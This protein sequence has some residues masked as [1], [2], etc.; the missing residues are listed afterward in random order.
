MVRIIRKVL[1]LACAISAALAC[2]FLFAIG[3]LVFAQ[4]VARGFGKMVPSAIDLAAFSMAAST[5][6]GLAWTFRKNEHIRV[7]LALNN[8]PLRLRRIVEI[9]NVS[10]GAALFGFIGWK[11]GEMTWISYDF[12]DVSIGLVPIPL[13]IPQLALTFGS[14]MACAVLVDEL[15]RLIGGQHEAFASADAVSTLDD[16]PS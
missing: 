12:G 10:L 13:W 2:F 7:L 8:V 5:F 3:V 11:T 1:D 16:H 6:L 9:V 4:V 14:G 15:T